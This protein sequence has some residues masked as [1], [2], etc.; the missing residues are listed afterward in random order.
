MGLL[1]LPMYVNLS[2]IVAM[3]GEDPH[4]HHSFRYE[5]SYGSPLEI[6]TMAFSPNGQQLAV[7]VNNQVELIDLD[8]GEIIREFK[9]R[10]FSMK[11]TQDGKRLYMISESDTHLLDVSSGTVIPTTNRHMQSDPGINIE[12]RNG[13]LLVKSLVPGGSADASES[14]QVGDELVAFSNGQ[15]GEMERITGWSLEAAKTA[16]EG[17]PGTFARV[18]ILPRGQY[19][20]RNEKTLTF[21][22]TVSLGS[23][24]VLHSPWKKQNYPK[25]IAWCMQGSKYHE[26]RD[27]ATGQAI[28]HIETIDIENIGRYA[29]SPDQKKFAVVASRK[30]REGYAVEVFDLEAQERLAFVPLSTKSYLDISFA[31]DNN[32]VLVGTWDTVEV[33]DTTKAQVVSQLTFGYEI[34]G[35]DSLDRT[36]RSPGGLM[37]RSVM[38][39]V[40]DGSTSNG[41]SSRQL[42][43]KIA[44][45]SQ[46]LVAVGDPRGSVGIWNLETDS[47]VSTLPAEH[48]APVMHLLFSE[49]GRW[50]AY[51][52]DGVLHIVDVSSLPARK[53]GS[54]DSPQDELQETT[55]EN[56]VSVTPA[57]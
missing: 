18:T 25:A 16:L 39:N 4:V 23:R 35:E 8:R 43:D 30:D 56:R 52:I 11:Y 17:Y 29:I 24:Q 13:K 15:N 6:R 42:V 41:Y 12:R 57:E 28:S 27:A 33:C 45:S 34:P 7:S 32:L 36:A 21:R 37:M 38:A 20:A 26:F 9:S 53:A 14:V 22:R 46:N 44:V 1:W 10:P 48:E 51:Y 40:A 49:D 55:E 2:L 50:L 3:S 5:T 47:L 31:A 19:G 54:E